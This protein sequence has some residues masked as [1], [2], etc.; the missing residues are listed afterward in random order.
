MIDHN[1]V[2]DLGL[3]WP[4]GRADLFDDAAGFMTLND[5]LILATLRLVKMVKVASAHT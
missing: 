2:A 4:D 1:A 3:G 5:D